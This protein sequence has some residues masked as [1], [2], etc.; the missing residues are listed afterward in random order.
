MQLS[1]YNSESASIFDITKSINPVLD[2]EGD[3]MTERSNLTE[4]IGKTICERYQLLEVIGQGGMGVVFKASDQID[5]RFV[6]IK[7][8]CF[9]T[10]SN[11]MARKRFY[12]EAKTGMALSHQNIVRTYGYGELEEDLI[13]I[14]MEY[15][16]GQSLKDYIKEKSPLSPKKALPILE[17]LCLALDYAHTN[18]ILHRD[19]KPANVLL[20]RSELDQIEVKL[21]DFGIAKLLAPNEDI[22]NGTNLTETGAILGTV[23][24]VAPEYLLGFD[25]T[26]ASDIYS[27]GVMLYQMLTG[28]CPVQG[29]SQEQ[30][31]YNK[32]YK[33]IETP[34]NEYPFLPEALDP[35]LKKVLHRD[36]KKRYN[37]TLELL[38]DFKNAIKNLY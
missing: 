25:L 38:E 34:S 8:L 24:Y 4:L 12:R 32:V 18:G 13:F 14:S 19:L 10:L 26:N 17:K 7:L 6:A 35:V 11:E 21:A 28:F 16:K 31:L 22:T 36:P 29:S 33:D 27:L 5:N 30:I 15:V 1:K 9:E 3:D 37:N 20:C 2:T 23:H